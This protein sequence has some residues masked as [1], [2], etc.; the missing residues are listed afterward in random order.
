M[1]IVET[2]TRLPANQVV[3]VTTAVCTLA[4]SDQSNEFPKV[5]I[6]GSCVVAK[7]A[8]F[9]SKKALDQLFA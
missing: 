9:S 5:N 8:M 2:T 6:Q 3:K 4:H 1:Q 7:D